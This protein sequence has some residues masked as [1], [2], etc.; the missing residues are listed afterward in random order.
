MVQSYRPRNSYGPADAGGAAPNRVSNPYRDSDIGGIPTVRIT[1][2]MYPNAYRDADMGGIPTVGGIPGARPRGAYGNADFGSLDTIFR[3]QSPQGF[4]GSVPNPYGDVPYGGPDPLGRDPDGPVWQ[5]FGR[6]MTPEQ[7]YNDEFRIYHGAFPWDYDPDAVVDPDPSVDPN[8]LAVGGGGG[9]QMNYGQALQGL[10]GSGI[11]D[12]TAVPELQGYAQPLRYDFQTWDPSTIDTTQL[13]TWDPT[14][15]EA[16]D[17]SQQYSNVD[18]MAEQVRNQIGQAWDPAIAA[19]GAP[20]QTSIGQTGGVSQGVSPD[21]GSFAGAMGFGDQYASDL[22]AANQGI[23]SNADLFAGRNAMLDRAFQMN[24][25]GSA[26]IAQQSRAAGL[27]GAATQEM[28]TRAALNRIEQNAQMQANQYN[29]GLQNQAGQYNTG[30]MNDA[31][32]QNIGL[33]NQAGQ[34]NTGIANQGMQ[35]NTDAFNAWLN[36]NVDLGNQQAMLG[37]EGQQGADQNR[38]AAILDMIAAAGSAGQTIDPSIYGM[39]A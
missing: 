35:A 27:S 26:D 21:L 6:G 8:P 22:A 18:A 14:L 32:L 17:F 4:R 23:Q 3:T 34:Y 24:R 25:Q 30:M 19:L 1:P 31:Y 28:L 16:P 12:P 9:T 7:I 36:S 11:F 37:Y 29:V 38:L 15:L 13:Q 39:V 2:N 20:L 5:G 33:Q 10:L